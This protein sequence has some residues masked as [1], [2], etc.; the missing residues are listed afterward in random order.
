M[1]WN[2]TFNAVIDKETYDLEIP[3][4]VKAHQ[5]KSVTLFE[6]YKTIS[7]FVSSISAMHRVDSHNATNQTLL[8]CVNVW[9]ALSASTEA[10]NG[11]AFSAVSANYPISACFTIEEATAAAALSV[12]STSDTLPALYFDVTNKPGK[13]PLT[14]KHCNN[15]ID[16]RIVSSDNSIVGKG[17]KGGNGLAVENVQDGHGGTRFDNEEDRVYIGAWSDDTLT[18][19]A[20]TSGGPALSGFDNYFKQ[21]I[22]I[23]NNGKVYGG[24]GGGGGGL[25]GVSAAEMPVHTWPLWFGCGGGGGSGVHADN[26]GSGG[27]AAVNSLGNQASDGDRS[28][29]FVQDGAVGRLEGVAGTVDGPAGGAGGAGGS[30]DTSGFD[31]NDIDGQIELR[32]KVPATEDTTAVDAISSNVT[33]FRAMTG[34]PGGRIGCPGFSDGAVA[35]YYT[36]DLELSKPLKDSNSTTTTATDISYNNVLNNYKLRV[37][38]AAGNIISL[39]TTVAPVTAG[40]GTFHGTGNLDSA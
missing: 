14:F 21:E 28:R 2:P 13:D 11:N 25:P 20:G 22:K 9:E 23:T 29:A 12:I 5:K 38:G 1:I 34:N 35:N 3:R 18:T 7:L 10:D 15:Q 39:Q 27:T 8:S 17:G 33:Y 30:W 4:D 6:Q 16:I 24:A 37:G 26:V 40:G 36:L 31:V 19:W 32:V